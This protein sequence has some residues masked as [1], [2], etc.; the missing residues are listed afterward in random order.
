[1]CQAQK[2]VFVPDQHERST[3][4]TKKLDVPSEL[5]QT[6]HAWQE[7]ARL[8]TF[9]AGMA[10]H[11]GMTS[12]PEVEGVLQTP[13]APCCC[14]EKPSKMVAMAQSPEALRARPPARAVGEALGP[15]QASPAG[16]RS[17]Q[18]LLAL[19]QLLAGSAAGAGLL[20]PWAPLIRPLEPQPPIPSG[21]CRYDSC[22]RVNGTDISEAIVHRLLP[23]SKTAHIRQPQDEG[24]V[25]WTQP[26]L[27]YTVANFSCLT[28]LHHCP[29][30]LQHGRH[31]GHHQ[32]SP[33][34]LQPSF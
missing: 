16:R 15:S 11:G 30:A 26:G 21:L 12:T 6:Q 10:S 24:L 34:V 14:P 33:A 32:S 2:Q 29:G 13:P 7:L 27:H 31:V 17:P 28:T 5:N 25:S 19:A 3:T 18:T 20:R 4:C 22:S 23:V 8:G 1:M 9:E